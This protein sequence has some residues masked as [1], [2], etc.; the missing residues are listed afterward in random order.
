MYIRL[1]SSSCAPRRGSPEISAEK[2]DLTI[3]A[4]PRFVVPGS[5]FR[6]AA[7]SPAIGAGVLISLPF[8]ASSLDLGALPSTA[9]TGI[10][11]RSVRRS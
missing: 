3:G 11:V 7:Q 1:A 8:G 2:P 4:D 9:T 6:L 10:G 5:D